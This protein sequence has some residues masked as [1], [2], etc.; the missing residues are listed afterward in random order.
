MSI[1]RF[2]STAHELLGNGYGFFGAEANA[3]R[4]QLGKRHRVLHASR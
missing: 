3:P 1:M 4:A 2:G